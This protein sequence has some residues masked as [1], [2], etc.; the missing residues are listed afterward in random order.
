[1]EAIT[2]HV[3]IFVVSELIFFTFHNYIVIYWLFCNNLDQF[4][5]RQHHLKWRSNLYSLSYFYIRF[6]CRDSREIGRK[7][8]R[9]FKQWQCFI[10]N[11]MAIILSYLFLREYE[12]VTIIEI[13][14]PH[15]YLTNLPRSEHSYTINKI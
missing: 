2:L 10:E 15:A 11:Q 12:S 7:T 6:S 3:Y 9:K 5:W 14:L 1:M 13:K 8:T 4:L